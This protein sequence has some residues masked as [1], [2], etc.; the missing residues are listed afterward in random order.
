MLDV[1][2]RG[3]S[4]VDGTGAPAGV[5]DVGIH[6]GRIVAVGEVDDRGTRE[7][8]ADGLVVAPGFVDPHT[9]YDAQLLGTPPPHHRAST[10]SRR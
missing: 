1:V 9:H 5:A 2:V 7:I 6:Q 4:V 10:V 3:G 8:D